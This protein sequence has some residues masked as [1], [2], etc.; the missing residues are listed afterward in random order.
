[1]PA[2]GRALPALLLAL[3]SCRG[4]A[5][6]P[7]QNATAAN[8]A[9]NCHVQLFA[10]THYKGANVYMCGAGE[11]PALDE[12]PDAW[13]GRAVRSFKSGARTRVTFWDQPGFAG[14]AI[15]WDGRT[16]KAAM[17]PPHSMK[18]TCKG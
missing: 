4:G 16:A 7:V 8:P 11:Y 15:T 13:D 1:M 5:Q 9:R 12:L 6:P 18:I 14:H 17:T 2:G 3:G 10:N